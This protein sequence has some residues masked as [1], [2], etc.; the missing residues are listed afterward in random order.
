VT[1]HG[2]TNGLVSIFRIAADGR[3]YA[4]FHSFAGGAADGQYPGVKLRNLANGSLWGSTTSGGA[5][6]FGT[7]FKYDP[8]SGV[9]TLVYSFAGNPDDGE[10]PSCRLRVGNDG[11]LYGVTLYGGAFDLGTFFRI[12]PAGV[13]SVLYNF[14]GGS[15]GRGPNSSLLRAPD[16]TFYGTT[17][18]GGPTSNGTVYKISP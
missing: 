5:N 12:T 15:D 2:G 3:G 6:G 18:S 10:Y 14:P 16:G 17:V 11:N 1:Y 9:T 4:V 8:G 13:L 7:I